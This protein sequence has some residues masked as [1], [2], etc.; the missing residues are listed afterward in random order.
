[1]SEKISR[2]V[3]SDKEQG[4]VP[5]PFIV[6]QKEVSE[7]VADGI[8]KELDEKH[9]RGVSMQQDFIRIYPNNSMLCHVVGFMNRE[10]TG[11]EGVEKSMD[12][13]LAGHPG[14]RFTERDRSGREI[15]AFRKMERPPRHGD[16]VRLTVDL[17]LQD[18]VETEM[19]AAVRQFRPKM[20]TCILMR[21]STGEILALA[22]RPHF[23]VNQRSG[24]PDEAR[25]NRAI[26]DMVEPGRVG[27]Q[28]GEAGNGHLLR[29][30][31]VHLRRNN[32]ARQPSRIWRVERP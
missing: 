25:K 2:T 29:T 15:P 31:Q 14:V 8:R 22:N 11:V 16:S 9:L 32:P 1:V 7:V 24:V 19:D 5:S 6:I 26:M 21:P 10:G 20:A 17:A 27:L 23:D 28:V 18:I 30:R 13:F 4:F 3:W 12:E